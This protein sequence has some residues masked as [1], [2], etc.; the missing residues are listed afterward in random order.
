MNTT[1]PYVKNYQMLQSPGTS[2]IEYQPTNPVAPGKTKQT[3]N[4]SYNGLLSSYSSTS[5]AESAK[6]PM[7]TEFMGNIAGKGWGFAS[8]ALTCAVNNASCSYVP[9]VSGCSSATN[10]QT[11]AMYVAYNNGSQWLYS[12]GQ[13]WGLAD[14]HAKFR[15]VGA[16]LSP[17]NTDWRTDPETG[18][19][20]TG[21]AGFYWWDGCHAWLFRPDYDF[22]I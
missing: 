21:R 12:K 5:I 9:S 18:Y 15:R 11:S 16:T 19:D 14:T 4:Y 1:Q 17:N 22:S 3:T 7:M 20:A 8:P 10:G 6:L 2:A 13:N